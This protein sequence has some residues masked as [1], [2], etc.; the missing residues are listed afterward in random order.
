MPRITIRE[1]KVAIIREQVKHMHETLT[2]LNV[3][4]A[5]YGKGHPYWDV[6]MDAHFESLR[7]SAGNLS[8]VMDDDCRALAVMY[9]FVKVGERISVVDQAIE[10]VQ[11]E[12]TENAVV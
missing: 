11:K 4:D 10:E 6:K 3:D 7:V 12:K 5:K 9:E 8:L 2:K 1:K